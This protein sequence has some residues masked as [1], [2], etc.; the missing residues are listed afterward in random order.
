[1]LVLKNFRKKA[2]QLYKEKEKEAN[3]DEINSIFFYLLGG[4]PNRPLAAFSAPTLE[5]TAAA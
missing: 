4:R 3:E 2:K 5:T 1:M